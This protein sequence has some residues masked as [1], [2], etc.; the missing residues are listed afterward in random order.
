MRIGKVAAQS[1]VSARTIRFWES[2]GLLADPA[3]PP[4]RAC[5]SA[6]RVRV[7]VPGHTVEGVL[8]AALP[9]TGRVPGSGMA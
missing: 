9:H 2:T 5:S 3:T 7:T 8:P 6:N 1:G 4:A